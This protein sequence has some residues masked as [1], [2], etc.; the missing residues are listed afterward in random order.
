MHG[1]VG[2]DEPVKLDMTNVAAYRSLDELLADESIDL[3]DITTPTFLH[4]E[5]ALAALASGKHVLCENPW[6]GPAHK[7][8]KSPM[9]PRPPEIFHA[10]YVP[11]FLARV[12]MGEGRH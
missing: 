8:G 4:H 11:A 3:I 2:S 10:R 6:P 1:N 9:P 12:E 5:Q 7:P